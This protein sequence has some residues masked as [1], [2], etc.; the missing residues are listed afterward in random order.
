[1]SSVYAVVYTAATLFAFATL[2]I[3]RV[4][5]SVFRNGLRMPA[6]RRST[7]LVFFVLSIAVIAA[8]LIKMNQ[9]Q[10]WAFHTR[11]VDYYSNL[12]KTEPANKRQSNISQAEVHERLRLEA[13][14]KL[15]SV[16]YG[17]LTD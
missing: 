10:E 14:R 9:I 4:I 1:M 17:V 7:K 6:E 15:F 5:R 13:A 11:C 16:P 12:A 3:I 8:V 2:N